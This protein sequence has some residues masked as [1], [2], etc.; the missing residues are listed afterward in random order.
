MNPCEPCCEWRDDV[1]REVSSD[2]NDNGDDA[3][4]KGGD[5]AEEQETH[6][7]ALTLVGEHKPGCV[8]RFFSGPWNRAV[9]RCRCFLIWFFLAW[10]AIAALF[11]KEIEPLNMMEDFLPATHKLTL[12][13]QIMQSEFTGGE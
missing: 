2:E 12:A 1:D 10:A 8:E 5:R 9:Y 7:T 13:K 11:A 6:E 3:E 4:A